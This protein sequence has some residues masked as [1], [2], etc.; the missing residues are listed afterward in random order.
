M[1]AG[2]AVVMLAMIGSS[3]AVMSVNLTGA[4]GT[5]STGAASTTPA[6]SGP[7]VTISPNPAA[8]DSGQSVT[9]NAVASGGTYQGYQWWGGTY[10]T[11]PGGNL[12]ITGA[13]SATYTTPVLTSSEYFCVNVTVTPSGSSAVNVSSPVDLVTVNPGLLVTT[14]TPTAPTVDSGQT[15]MLT[16]TATYGTPSLTYQWYS[17]GPTACSPFDPI[18]GATAATYS[19]NPAPITTTSYCVVVGDHSS[20][21]WAGVQSPSATITVVPAISAP[22]PTPSGDY[23]DVGQSFKLMAAPSGGTNSYS[24]QWYSGSTSSPSAC[25]NKVGLG[26]AQTQTVTPT[27]IGSTYYCYSVTDTS[28]NAV[29]KVSPSTAVVINATL[30]AGPISPSVVSFDLYT[31][32]AEMVNLTAKASGG[33]L[34]PPSGGYSTY[35]YQWRSGT[36]PQCGSD[37]NISGATNSWLVVSSASL[38]ASL[39]YCVE[40]QDANG[41]IAPSSPVLV[42]I[43]PQLTAAAPSPQTSQIDLGRAATLKANPNGGTTGTYSYQWFQGSGCTLTGG[44]WALSGALIPGAIGSTL[45]IAPSANATYFYRVT[46]NSTGLLE[47]GQRSEC[48]PTASVTV[49]PTM[50][51][52]PPTVSPSKTI[53]AGQSVTLTRPSVPAGEGTPV[54]SYQWR[55]G[56]SSNCS[57]DAN[58]ASQTGTTF[59]PFIPP[60]GVSWY[61]YAVTD[62]S[63]NAP[64]ILSVTVSVTV[65]SALSAGPISSPYGPA[66]VDQGPGGTPSQENV[67]L[68]ASVGGGTGSYSYQWY[69]GVAATCSAIIIPANLI[70]GATGLTYTAT[71]LSSTLAYCYQVT[72]QST[73]REVA[74][75]AAPFL[76]IVE[77]PLVAA[78]PTASLRSL[79]LGLTVTLTAA[80]QGGYQ[81]HSAYAAYQWFTASGPS[82]TGLGLIASKTTSP[83]TIAPTTTGTVYYCYRVTDFSNG[84]PVQESAYSTT[85]VSITVY[86]TV[87]ANGGPT[88][89]DY[90]TGLWTGTSYSCTGAVAGDHVT[91]AAAPSGGN[92]SNYVYTWYNGTSSVC[93]SSDPVMTGHVA[94]SVNVIVPSTPGSYYCYAVGDGT[95]NATSLTYFLDP[96]PS[97]S[98]SSPAAAVPAAAGRAE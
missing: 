38:S 52:G 54:I 13:T 68:L 23:G 36:Y 39:Y 3:L 29:A 26:T 67:T 80:A 73:P 50:T 24:F 71:G 78:K 91:L 34:A 70:A 44:V 19:P 55:A 61:C 47:L 5:V 98:S 74:T 48:S 75:T 31:T 33:A 77:L 15:V 1:I 6:A 56:T 65:N 2:V 11:C 89:K 82:C 63:V 97:S 53:D 41:T 86:P 17:G 60:V 84:N 42:T 79:D 27:A 4:A 93:G 81:N 94:S 43:Y 64:T 14:P 10:S 58:N 22:A 37:T 57:L 45:T 76:V 28:T 12:P 35:R 87:A 59:G 92:A 62:G 21:S 51:P 69:S 16:E 90:R 49:N 46:D 95:E 25:N 32:T 7:S 83:A 66:V 72:D 30:A 40:V 8:V 85:A 9:L 88:C 18:S 20:T 96:A